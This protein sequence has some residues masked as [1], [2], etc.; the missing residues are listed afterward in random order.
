M[1]LLMI[2]SPF[3]QLSNAFI[4]G[5][6]YFMQMQHAVKVITDQSQEVQM[7]IEHEAFCMV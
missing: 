5:L 7:S 6:D 4:E 2:S 1:Y 3:E